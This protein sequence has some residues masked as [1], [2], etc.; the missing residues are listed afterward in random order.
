MATGTIQ[1][2]GYREVMTKLGRVSKESRVVLTAALREAAWPVQSD[3]TSRIS[4]Y[5]E[6]G[7]VGISVRAGGVSVEQKAKKVTGK[8]PDFGALQMVKGFIPALE[9][10]RDE[11]L[12][13]VQYALDALIHKEGF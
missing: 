3:T 11:T 12:L 2:T 8:R 4:R 10:N 6:V 13:G 5:R 9:D 1:V 7:P